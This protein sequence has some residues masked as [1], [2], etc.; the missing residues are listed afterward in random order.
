MGI[1]LSFTCPECALNWIA[2]GSGDVDRVMFGASIT[3]VCTPCQRVHEAGIPIPRHGMFSLRRC[4]LDRL[5]PCPVCGSD[6]VRVWKEGDPCPRCST[7]VT[8]DRDHRIF[9]D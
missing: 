1:R 2:S 6:Q 8:Q 9:V 5:S 3:V 4:D 7:K